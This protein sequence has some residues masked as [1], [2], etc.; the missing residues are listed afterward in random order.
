MASVKSTVKEE[1][2]SVQTTVQSEMKSYS[3]V[4]SKTCSVALSQRKLQSA[5]KL[6]AEKEDRSRNV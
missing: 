2:K 6:A 4:L 5:V 3:S 1:L